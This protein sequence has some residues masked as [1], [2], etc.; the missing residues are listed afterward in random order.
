MPPHDES[1]PTCGTPRLMTE[2]APG[3]H[4]SDLLKESG[5][6]DFYLVNDGLNAR[7]TEA[8]NADPRD[9]SKRRRFLE[10]NFWFAIGSARGL[11]LI[12]REPMGREP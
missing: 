12:L 6:Y 8:A 4:D 1:T 11:T 9:L 7:L 5:E 2:T 3:Y 10:T